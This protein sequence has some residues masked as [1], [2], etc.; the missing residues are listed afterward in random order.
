[1]ECLISFFVSSLSV[2]SPKPNFFYLFPLPSSLVDSIALSVFAKELLLFYLQNKDIVET[3]NWY[4]D[5][6]LVPIAICVVS[7]IWPK[8][9]GIK[10]PQTRSHYG[11]GSLGNMARTNGVL[12]PHEHDNSRLSSALK[13]PR[14]LHT[15]VK[16]WCR[17]PPC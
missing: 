10:F 6:L 15:E 9:I 3:E 11:V 7:T 5:L 13:E 8:V 2:I 1:M 17:G 14:E 16:R 12:V 4:F